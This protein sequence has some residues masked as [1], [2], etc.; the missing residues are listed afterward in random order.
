MR[1]SLGEKFPTKITIGKIKYKV[2]PTVGR[3]ITIFEIIENDELNEYEKINLILKIIVKAKTRLFFMSSD[4]KIQLLKKIFNDIINTHETKKRNPKALDFQQDSQYIYG[5]FWQA[6]N[7]DLAQQRDKMH[8][9][10]FCSLL[11]S[12]PE[13]T[14]LMQIISIRTRPMPKPTKYNA[15]E[16]MRLARLKQEYG[17]QKT[18][19]EKAED[20]QQSLANLAR[21][22]EAVATRKK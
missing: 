15:E 13:D 19:K 17:L 18:E 7:I 5:A 12:L 3:I 9:W 4:N 11:A 2:V 8:W 21:K 14:R 6:Y 20:W 16:R 22:L 10:A 1:L